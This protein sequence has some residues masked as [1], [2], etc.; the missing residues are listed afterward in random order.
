MEASIQSSCKYPPGARWELR[1]EAVAKVHFFHFLPLTLFLKTV[2]TKPN[3]PNTLTKPQI[4]CFQII[5]KASQN[6]KNYL[7]FM[8]HYN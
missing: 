3:S 6:K 8:I 4:Q 1:N 2:N 7:A 5:Q